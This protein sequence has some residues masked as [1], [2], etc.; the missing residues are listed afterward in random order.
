[1]TASTFQT[2]VV[3]YGASKNALKGRTKLLQ[4]YVDN[5][6]SCFATSKGK[7]HDPL[8]L[9]ASPSLRRLMELIILRRG[10]IVLASCILEHNL[11]Y[12]TCEVHEV[13][14]N[15]DQ[16]GQ[17]WCL[18]MMQEVFAHLTKRHK[19]V[20]EVQIYCEGANAAACKCYAK[21]FPD[22]HKVVK[23]PG[24]QV[25]AFAKHLNADLA[26][27]IRLRKQQQ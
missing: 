24:G 3:S 1:M 14:V 25:I 23:F 4:S 10:D 9:L 5:V 13:C 27:P 20:R 18:R 17:G 26:S 15:L 16:R 21:T 11:Y 7:G 12:N 8:A 6:V 2:M 19:L 22:F